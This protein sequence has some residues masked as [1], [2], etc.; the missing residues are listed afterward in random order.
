MQGGS[1]EQDPNG[2]SDAEMVKIATT[3]PKTAGTC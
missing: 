3:M 1:G 2:G